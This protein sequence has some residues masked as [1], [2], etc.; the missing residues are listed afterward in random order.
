MH[1]GALA[2]LS[3]IVRDALTGIYH[4]RWI[5]RGGPVRWPVRSIDLNPL[6]F[7]I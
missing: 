2:H 1:N 7:Y 5:V 3:L 6:D 4:D